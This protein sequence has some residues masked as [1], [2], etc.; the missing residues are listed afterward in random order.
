MLSGFGLYYMF[1][2]RFNVLVNLTELYERNDWKKSDFE[3][4][5]KSLLDCLCSP[6]AS[7]ASP[8]A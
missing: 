4:L 7:Y 5:F 3:R 2:Y 1:D 6:R 8:I